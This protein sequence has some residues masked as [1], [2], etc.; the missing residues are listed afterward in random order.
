MI[1]TRMLTHEKPNIIRAQKIN[2]IMMN[3]IRYAN[4]FKSVPYC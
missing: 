3:W 4:N 1:P 2:A